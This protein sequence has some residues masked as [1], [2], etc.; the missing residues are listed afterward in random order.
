MRVGMKLVAITVLCFGYA[1]AQTG[2]KQAPVPPGTGGGNSCTASGPN[3]AS[4][5]SG[6]CP[7]GQTASCQG[8]VSGQPTCN[9]I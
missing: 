1:Y 9:C 3:G 4:C 5:N 2:V 6:V 7:S 8:S